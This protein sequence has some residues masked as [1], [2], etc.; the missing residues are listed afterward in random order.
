MQLH[1]NAVTLLEQS[2]GWLE[3]REVTNSLVPLKAI[4]TSQAKWT[5]KAYYK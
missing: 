5:Y 2:N 1:I 4:F 3:S